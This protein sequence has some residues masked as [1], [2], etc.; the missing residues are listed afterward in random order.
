MSQVGLGLRH[1]RVRRTRPYPRGIT[2][3]GMPRSTWLLP[4]CSCFHHALILQC[5]LCPWWAAP[6]NLPSHTDV[7]S[8]PSYNN[9]AP[10]PEGI[11]CTRQCVN[12]LCGL[13]HLLHTT[14]QCSVIPTVQKRKLRP[15][16]L[17]PFS[18]GHPVG[19]GRARVQLSY[20]HSKPKFCALN[21]SAALEPIL[22]G[23]GSRSHTP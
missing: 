21:H 9:W 23:T 5:P 8:L 22:C 13:F 15:M 1:S 7:P 4:L 6:F 2:L 20:P 3:S 16:E 19:Q 12:V 11:P 18:Q 17:D 14:P 10:F